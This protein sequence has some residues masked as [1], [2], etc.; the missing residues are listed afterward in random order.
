MNY[1]TPRCSEYEVSQPEI[2]ANRLEGGPSVTTKDIAAC[3]PRIILKE[4][5]SPGVT[6]QAKEGLRDNLIGRLRSTIRIW[7]QR[8]RHRQE[9]VDAL[10]Q[11]H[12]LARDLGT[13]TEEL[14]A[15]A[16]KP[17]WLP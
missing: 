7:A 14:E 3:A 4:L 10:D 1:F 15:W 17:F 16:K 11:D 6:E 8:R 13:T 9:L 2:K 12:R 5:Q